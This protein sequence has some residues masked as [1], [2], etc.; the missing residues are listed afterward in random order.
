MPLRLGGHHPLR[1]LFVKGHISVGLVG[2][3]PNNTVNLT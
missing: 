3:L 1:H 2:L